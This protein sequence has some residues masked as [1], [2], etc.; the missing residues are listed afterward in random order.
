MKRIDFFTHALLPRYLAEL[1]SRGIVHHPTKPARILSD[2]AY[3]MDVM[4][5]FAPGDTS[6][7]TMMGPDLE[8]MVDAKLAVKLAR[9][10]NDELAQLCRDQP[11]H[12]IAAAG[13]LPMDDMDAA[14]A[15]CRRAIEQLGLRGI[16]IS[17]NIRGEYLDSKRLYPIYEMME[18][19]DLPIWIHPVFAPGPR[20]APFD[21]ELML[22]WPMDTSMTMFYLARS[23]VF[24]R[25]PKIK[26]VTHHC[27]AFIPAFYPRLKAQYFD[28]PAYLV[29]P[30]SPEAGARHANLKRFY[31]D[32]AIYGDCTDTLE[33]GCRFFGTDRVVYGTDFP[34]MTP[35]ELPRTIAS[36]ER[37][38]VSQEE[39]EKIFFRN[40]R[41]L[42][43]LD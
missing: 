37:L 4:D 7:M 25:F 15:E 35:E 41:K 3:R 13:M 29:E 33:L 32:T 8:S 40:A 21:I 6:V 42:L 31:T 20:S 2:V 23:E 28:N 24:E 26:F 36:V 30:V 17:S 38:P 14:C 5:A 11:G 18:A 34:S 22:G 16:Q 39:K 19:Y 43:H 27:G 10:A 9:V 1:D 12:F